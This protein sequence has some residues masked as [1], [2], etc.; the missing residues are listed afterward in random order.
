M[1]ELEKQYP[2]AIHQA[3]QWG[4]MDAFQ[5]VNNVVYFKYFENS[6]IEYFE[7]TGI[8]QYM[9][10]YCIGPI[11]GS[12]E[13]KFLAPLTFPDQITIVARVIALKVKRFTMLY[14][15]YSQSSAKKVAEG[16]GEIIYFNY[17]LHHSHEIPSAIRENIISLEADFKNSSL[18]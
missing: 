11:L 17:N 14:E 9:K 18:S 12:T 10:Q 15:V 4:D 3:I 8:N 6:R 2:I 7:R 5:H 13:C 1:K 16:R